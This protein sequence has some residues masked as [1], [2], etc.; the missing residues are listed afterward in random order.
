MQGLLYLQ[1]LIHKT[2]KIKYEKSITEIKID[3]LH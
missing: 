1:I 3:Y 2:M